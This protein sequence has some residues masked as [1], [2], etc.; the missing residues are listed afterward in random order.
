V[1]YRLVTAEKEL[2]ENTLMGSIKVL[3]DVL[4]A[5]SPEA[6]GRSMRITRCVRH[7]VS[8]FGLASP[9][10]FE[11]AAML[12]Q[13]G[14]VT[15]DPELTQAAYL[16]NNLSPED[17]AH[18]DEHPRVARD[19]L[20]TIPRLEPIAW[21]VS[22]QFIKD[23]NGDAPPVPASSSD[24][25]RFGAKLL[26]LAVAYDDLRMQGMSEED[27]IARLRHRT[28]EFG[29]EMIDAMGD[30]KREG[31]RTELRKVPTAKLAA[32]MILQQEIRNKA[33][34][35]VVAKGQ[36]VTHALLLKLVNFSRAGTI[37]KEVMALVPA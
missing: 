31:G 7:L 29:R 6:F 14:C 16:G 21:M 10:R 20:V 18:Y 15:L 36:E 8:K 17:K 27:A 32:G 30:M 26:K 5:V 11:A 1:Q 28:G 24:A 4:S 2:L 33:G 19:L 12:S 34:M 3:T 9:W 25:M 35:L 23:A 13:L 22:Q 37:A